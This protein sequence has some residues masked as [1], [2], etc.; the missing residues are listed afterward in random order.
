MLCAQGGLVDVVK[1]LDFGLV[2]EVKRAEDVRLTA[3]DMVLGTPQYMA[4]E[5]IKS[6]DGVDARADLYALGATAFYLLTG[7]DVFEGDST[8]ELCAH[9]LHTAPGR[10][11]AHAAVPAELDALIDRCLAKDPAARPQDAREF[12]ALLDALET[13]PWTQDAATAWWSTHGADLD[14]PGGVSISAPTMRH[15]SAS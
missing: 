13:A 14:R 9:H 12:G 10:A 3:Q 4:P 1:V 6:A 8:V 2:K 7:R 15:A 5:A 11:S